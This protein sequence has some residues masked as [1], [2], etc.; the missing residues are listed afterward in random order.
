LRQP[1]WQ[2]VTKA[3]ILSDAT[4]LNYKKFIYCCKNCQLMILSTSSKDK[5]FPA[6]QWDE[7]DWDFI[8]FL[9]LQSYNS[10][11]KFFCNMLIL[12]YL[13]KQRFFSVSY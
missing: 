10:I 8:P 7:R 11:I 9:L 4:I 13:K 1:F 12:L 5:V 2:V 3:T 6:P